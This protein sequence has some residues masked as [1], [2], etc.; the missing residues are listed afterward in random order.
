MFISI[1]IEETY[2]DKLNG[3]LTVEMYKNWKDKWGSYQRLIAS[4]PGI[5]NYQARALKSSLDKATPVSA[6]II[7][8]PN[9]KLV[10][11]VDG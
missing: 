1:S 7:K 6:D 3:T 5:P 10:E 8:F 9:L 4:I 2:I 11:E